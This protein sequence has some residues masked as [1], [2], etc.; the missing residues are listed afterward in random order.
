MRRSLP[1]GRRR[2]ILTEKHKKAL[3][4]LSFLLF[5]GFLV[6]VSVFFGKP[7]LSFVED[8]E[9]FR[10]WVEEKGFLSRVV[11]MGMVAFQ[12]VIALIP[13][14]PLEI[15]A[16]IAFGSIEGT[17][18]CLFGIA[19]GSAIVFLLVRRFGIKLVEVFFPMEKILSLKFLKNKKKVNAVVFFLMMIPGTPKD[20]ISYF[21]GL[22]PMKLRRWLLL[23]LVSRIPSVLTS[24]VGGDALQGKQYLF[25]AIV[26]AVTALVSILGA[27]LY[28]CFVEN[29]K[30]RNPMASTKEEQ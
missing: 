15:V 4:I 29:R 11:F 5:L 20:L 8:P 3:G 16:G 24:T 18:L 1:K 13:G 28:T 26:F 12:V 2:S 25:A 27:F 19:I 21:V 6:F 7:L 10:A 30:N 23:V 14:E 9:A 22:T 17:L